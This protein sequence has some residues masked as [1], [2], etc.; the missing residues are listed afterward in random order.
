MTLGVYQDTTMSVQLDN[1]ISY[2][3]YTTSDYIGGFSFGKRTGSIV[4][5]CH[6]VGTFSFGSIVFP[7]YCDTRIITN[8]IEDEL[9]LERDSTD[10]DGDTG[11][12]RNL[13]YYGGI[14]SSQAT[15][16]LKIDTLDTDKLYFERGSHKVNFSGITETSIKFIRGEEHMIHWNSAVHENQSSAKVWVRVI[17]MDP[18]GFCYIRETINSDGYYTIKGTW[19][20]SHFPGWAIILIAVGAIMV[21]IIIVASVCCGCCACCAGCC[22]CCFGMCSRNNKKHK[23]NEYEYES[24]PPVYMQYNNPQGYTAGVPPVS[25]A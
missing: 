16:D 13:C 21:V 4:V 6:S 9:S 8:R 14:K 5:A 11:S 3:P 1:G 25:Y 20:P 10:K 24:Q 22:A 15:Y 12:G 2:G 7:D 17:Q 23:R 18:S 19:N